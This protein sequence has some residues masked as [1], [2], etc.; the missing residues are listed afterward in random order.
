MKLLARYKNG[1]VSVTRWDDGTTVRRTEDDEFRPAFAENVDC[2]ITDRC[3]GG[4]Q[5]CYE[6][7]TPSGKHGDILNDTFIDSLHPYTEMALNG[8]DLSHPHLITFLS[9]LK[10]KKVIANLTVNQIH[11]ERHYNFI[12]EL[13]DKKLIWGLGIS[14]REPTDAFINLVK[15]IPNAVIHTING[16]LTENDL[17]RLANHDLKILILGYKTTGR[18][19]EYRSNNLGELM[20][21]TTY[22]GLMLPVIVKEGW[23]KNLSFDNLAIKQLDVKRLM[24]EEEWER[25]YMGDDGTFTFYIDLV[26]QTFSKNS[27][28]AKIK[29]IPINGMT[30][31]EMFEIVKT[32]N[33]ED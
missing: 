11:F 6:G 33:W 7:C 23:F 29:S 31:D 18:G 32:T 30:I 28:I 2:K 15:T 17:D 27:V 5:F 14:L 20:K 3:D 21:N 4:C 9:R 1:N 24:S 22:L 26:N 19:L 10:E 12:K 13:L 8:N 25:F 16:I